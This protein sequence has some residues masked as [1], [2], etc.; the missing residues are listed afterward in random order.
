MKRLLI[1]AAALTLLGGPAAFADQDQDHHDHS[2]HQNGG[3]QSQGHGSSGNSSG[4]QQQQQQ[5]QSSHQTGGSNGGASHTSQPQGGGRPDW[6]AYYR[7]N[8]DLQK[9]YRQNQQS[10]TYHESVDAFAERHYAEHGKAE[11]RNLPTLQGQQYPQGQGGW[12]GRG[13]NDNR[14]QGQG[15]QRW[16]GGDRGGVRDYRSFQRNTFAQHRYRLPAF[17]WPRGFEYRRFTFGQYLPRAFFGQDYWLYDYSDYGLPYP[18]PGTAWVRYGPDALLIDRESG[19]IVQVIYGVFYS[20]DA[21]ARP[22]WA[23]EDSPPGSLLFRA[24]P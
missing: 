5:Q 10:S 15:Q 24:Q 12:Q 11:G 20:S 3:G 4:G 22:A 6:N 8:P 19:E 7:S 14:Y 18:P 1:S 23:R 13:G 17:R 9:A 16:Q 2:Q 21:P